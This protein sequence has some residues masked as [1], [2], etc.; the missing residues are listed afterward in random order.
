MC[1]TSF[2]R[3]AETAPPAEGVA[4]GGSWS[5]PLGLDQRYPNMRP[6]ASATGFAMAADGY[7]LTSLDFLRKPG[8]ELA[9]LVDAETS[10]GSIALCEVVGTEPTLNLA[11]IKLAVYS[12]AEPP[13]LTPVTIADNEAIRVGHW[14]IAVG[15]PLG[16]NGS[17]TRG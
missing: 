9:D 13:V 11:V 14:A 8:G 1:L 2:E 6:L 16:P 15:D 4:I 12:E 7:V 5:E 10:D 3:T 17:S